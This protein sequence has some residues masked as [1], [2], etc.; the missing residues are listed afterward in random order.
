MGLGSRPR[1][2]HQDVI[3]LIAADE[4]GHGYR[5]DGRDASGHRTGRLVD[6][7]A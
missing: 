1:P 5:S 7:R 3:V 4:F 6:I 2:R